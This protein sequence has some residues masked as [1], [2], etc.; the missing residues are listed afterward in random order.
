VDKANHL[1]AW[2]CPIREVDV[3]VADALHDIEGHDK[4]IDD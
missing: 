2:P 3:D 1:V 4:P